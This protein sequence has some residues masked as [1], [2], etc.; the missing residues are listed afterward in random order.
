MPQVKWTKPAL[1]DLERLFTFLKDKNPQAAGN[2]AQKIK[3]TADNLSVY[4]L[5]GKPM[6]DDT[7]RLEISASF[8]KR[9][10]IL[11]YMFD[12][13][14]NVVIIRVWHSLENRS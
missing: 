6:E 5:M 11:R 2:A 1:G 4:P 3:D 12:D 7:G 10:Y 14:G 13:D 8:G 9:G